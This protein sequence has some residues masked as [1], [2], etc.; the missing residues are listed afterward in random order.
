[1]HENERNRLLNEL[2]RFLLAAS[3]MRQAAAAAEHLSTER[4]NGDLC[5]ALETAIVICYSRPFARGN[6][7]GTLGAEWVPP[8][9]ELVPPRSGFRSGAMRF[10]RSFSWQERRRR[11]S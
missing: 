6:K 5:R 4:L 3:D 10:Q 8:A 9:P 11:S 7:A 2:R 1:M